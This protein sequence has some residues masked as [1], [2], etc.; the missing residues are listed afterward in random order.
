MSLRKER[1]S[2]FELLRLVLMFF[3]T[4]NHFMVHGL[5][6]LGFNKGD[7]I[8]PI[9]LFFDSFFIIGVNA[10]VLISG[11]HGIKPKLKSFINL[12]IVCVFYILLTNYTKNI[13]HLD[14]NI[15]WKEVL[16]CFLPFSH[17]PY[18]FIRE[19]FYLFLISP[20]LNS[21]VKRISKGEFKLL[22]LLFAIIVFYFGFFMKENI[23][24]NGYSYVNFI[25]LYLIGRYINVYG[26]TFK[27]TKF[28]YL[29]GYLG[30]SLLVFLLS[31]M[32]YFISPDNRAYVIRG[33]VFAYNNPLI[34]MSSILFVL[35]FSK[36]SIKSKFINNIAQS[37]LAIY[38]VQ[39]SVGFGKRIIYKFIHHLP[40]YMNSWLLIIV[41]PVLGI[42][43]MIFCLLI[44]RVRLRLTNMIMLLLDKVGLFRFW[45]KLAKN[46]E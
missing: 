43:L 25:F 1:E 27:Y 29:F 22:L 24:S 26:N 30:I 32:V 38:L 17:S 23:D 31:L 46:F 11:F 37:A 39:D 40:E 21:A 41:L 13:V 12:Y 19:Y 10:F 7:I 4:M 33:F 16:K 15:E 44:D 20:I 5:S 14:F 42:L 34:I 3:I 45:D 6:I 8:N 9:G 2:N 18:W 36:L 35:F 28:N